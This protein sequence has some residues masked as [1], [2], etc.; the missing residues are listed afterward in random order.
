LLE[1]PNFILRSIASQSDAYLLVIAWKLVAAI[2]TNTAVS[3][4]S[5]DAMRTGDSNIC[6]DAS[7]TW[8]SLINSALFDKS[9][10]VLQKIISF[11]PPKNIS[12]F[13]AHH[14]TFTK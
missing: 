3:M 13:P 5:L 4:L 8:L 10:H 9:L 11:Q 12:F 6:G 14:A 1:I 2:Y 7:S